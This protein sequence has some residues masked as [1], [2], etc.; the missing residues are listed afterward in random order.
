M[1]RRHTRPAPPVAGV[2]EGATTFEVKDKETLREWDPAE[3]GAAAPGLEQVSSKAVSLR[4][5]PGTR[6]KTL[7]SGR[8]SWD[9]AEP[10]ADVL[11]DTLGARRA[12]PR[13]GFA[14]VT[15]VPLRA[16]ATSAGI[17]PDITPDAPDASVG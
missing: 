10:S 17:A 3:A 5:K 6:D 8:R 15:S 4:S 9:Q 1:R 11:A 12:G 7:S 2:I 16:T 14:H 13:L